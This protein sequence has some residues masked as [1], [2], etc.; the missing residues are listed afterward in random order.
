MP[1]TTINAAKEQARTY[2]PLILAQITFPLDG[3]ILRLST[4]PLNAAEGG[5]QYSGQ[6]WLG[7]ISKQDIGA[8]QQLSES[9]IDIP[10]NVRL[11]VA[12]D[13]R[14]IWQDY[15]LAKGFKN[16]ELDLIFIFADLSQS[17]Y[18]FSTDNFTR[19]VG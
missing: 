8:I 9:G 5:Y 19:F 14:V 4:H 2:Q 6:N 16:A 10:L 7:R 12:D 15:E 3:T 13:D 18:V 1:L 17:P 11:N